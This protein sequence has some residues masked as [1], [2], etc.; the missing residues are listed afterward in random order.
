[1][2]PV[3][4]VKSKESDLPDENDLSKIRKLIKE[5]VN[6]GIIKIVIRARG[7]ERHQDGAVWRPL[8]GNHILVDLMSSLRVNLQ[9]VHVYYCHHGPEDGKEQR[10]VDILFIK[11]MDVNLVRVVSYLWSEVFSSALP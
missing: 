11:S 6:E 9:D 5:L 3:V 10:Y 2:K 7:A 1:M 8:L 4:C